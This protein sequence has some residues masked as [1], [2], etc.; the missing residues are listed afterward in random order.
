MATLTFCTILS[1]QFKY[2]TDIAYGRISQDTKSLV[3]LKPTPPSKD[4]NGQ[5]QASTSAIAIFPQPLPP[6]EQRTCFSL[7]LTKDT[8]RVICA[9]KSCTPAILASVRSAWPRGIIAEGRPEDDV[10]EFQLK[11]YSRTPS[12]AQFPQSNINISLCSLQ[13][14][15]FRQRRPSP[16]IQPPP[17]PRSPLP[18]PYHQSR[19]HIGNLQITHKG[20]LDL[21][22]SSRYRHSSRYWRSIFRPPSSILPQLGRQSG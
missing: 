19:T 16:H 12:R 4:S 21:R 22:R 8:L 7:S 9:P 3:F 20:P 15:N 13:C 17:S 5:N 11:G 6:G 18:P 14:I 10:Y 2:V 1:H